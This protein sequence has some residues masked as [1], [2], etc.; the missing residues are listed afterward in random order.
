MDGKMSKTKTMKMPL[1]RNGE[2]ESVLKYKSPSP[3]P[4]ILHVHFHLSFFFGD[5]SVIPTPHLQVARYVTNVSI[6]RIT[7]IEWKSRTKF[8]SINEEPLRF[9]L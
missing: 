9:L 5:F 3:S 6:E 2:N 7:K 1:D 8:L 4:S